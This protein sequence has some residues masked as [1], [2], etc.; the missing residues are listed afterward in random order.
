MKKMMSLLIGLLLTASIFS[1]T[2]EAEDD[3]RAKLKATDSGWK[4]GGV[5]NVNFSQAAFSSNWPSGGT[6]SMTLTSLVN[7]FANYSDGANVWDNTL[8]L[9]YGFSKI[10]TEDLVK[11]DDKID[12]TSKYGRQAFSHWYYAALFNFKSQ[13]TPTEVE[14]I[15]TSE[16][17]NPGTVLFAIG[18]DYKPSD[19]LT[20]FISPVTYRA[21]ITKDDTDGDLGGYMRVVYKQP[22]M[23]NVKFETKAEAFSNYDE[24]PQNLYITW[25]NLLAMKVN[26]YISAN[27]TFSLINQPGMKVV[28]KEVLGIGLTYVF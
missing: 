10:D 13:M 5:V 19:R 14:G 21:V 18:M 26:Q 9:G 7:I 8:E 23:E 4:T 2:T 24:N 17:L 16:F 15:T 28:Y 11:S 20:A 6:N 25:D 3:L 27:V 12:L 22:L 1:Q